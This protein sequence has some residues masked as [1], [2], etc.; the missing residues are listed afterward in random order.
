M[1]FRSLALASVRF[2][3]GHETTEAEID[4]A[5]AVFP[6]LVDKVRRLTAVLGRA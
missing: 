5:I 3:L 1:L 2:S 6:D 4:Q